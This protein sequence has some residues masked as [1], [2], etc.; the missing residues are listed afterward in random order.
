[1]DDEMQLVEL[2]QMFSRVRR[3]GVEVFF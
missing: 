2:L 1:M 3:K